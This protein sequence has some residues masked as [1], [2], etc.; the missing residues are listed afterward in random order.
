[1]KKN[2]MKRVIATAMVAVLLAT[3]P[4]NVALGAQVS[5]VKLEREVFKEVTEEETRKLHLSYKF[6]E[7]EFVVSDY[8]YQVL[9]DDA[10]A[11]NAEGM[12]DLPAKTISILI[13]QGKTVK[14]V[15]VNAKNKSVYENMLVAPS[16][17]F[18][19][20]TN[21]S[22]SVNEAATEGESAV[23]QNTVSQNDLKENQPE[24]NAN[25]TQ[26]EKKKEMLAEQETAK[27]AAS[28]KETL[29]N[30]KNQ[31]EEQEGEDVIKQIVPKELDFTNSEIY[32]RS[33]YI[34]DTLYPAKNY[35]KG[36]V[37]TVRGFQ[38]YTITLYPM[39]YSGTTLTYTDEMTVDITF[40][41][42]NTQSEY[43]PTQE[44]LAF[45]GS[46]IDTSQYA[47]TYF[48]KT[49]SK[50]S[51]GSSSK[52]GKTIAGSGKIDYII[53]TDK[54]LVKTFQE[55]ADYKASKGLRT[56]VVSTQKIYKKYKGYDRAEKI[57]NFIQDAYSKNKVTYILLGGDGD[58][59]TNSKQAV[60][61]TRLL[62][63]EPVSSGEKP[64]Y[65]A[66]DLYYSCLDGTY[67]RNN[68]HKYGE[69][70]DG[71]NGENVDL[72]ADV[73]VG[74]APVDNKEEAKNFITKT[75]NYETR[76]KSAQALMIGENL[77]GNMQCSAELAASLQSDIEAD[78]MTDT[79]RK[80]RDDKI[81]EEFINLY[82]DVNSFMKQLY[83]SDLEL[84]G[85]TISLLTEYT[86]ILKEYVETG[87]TQ[88]QLDAADIRCL[89]G[90]FEELAQAVKE[91]PSYTEQESKLYEEI[92]YFKDY[93][94]SCEGKSF[95][96]M[97]EGSRFYNAG[98]MATLDF[99][100]LAGNIFGGT[101]KD[102]IRL[103]SSSN[104]MVTRGFPEKYTVDTLYDRDWVNQHWETADLLAK[105]NASPELINHLGHS[106]V[107][108]V[109]RLDATQI[110]TLANENAFFF[111]S[112][113]CYA[114]SFDNCKTTGK[115]TK[116][117]SIA[118][119]LLVS[120]NKSGAFACI[121]NSRYGWY[122]SDPS[123]TKGPSQI[124]D[125]LFWDQ[126]LHE[127]DKSLG[128]ILAKS[129]E[130]KEAMSYLDNETYGTVMRYCYYEINL[131]G[132]PETSLHDLKDPLLTQPK[133][134]VKKA[135]NGRKLTWNA[136][137]K[138]SKY[139][140]Y[141][142]TSRNGE[143]EKIGTTKD[144]SYTDKT[145]QKGKTYYYKVAA[146]KKVGSKAYY[147]VSEMKKSK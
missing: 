61:P 38:V 6:G 94:G 123:S 121:V 91:N 33:V 53:I 40:K 2:R 104:N 147:R 59:K 55:L 140:V 32:N 12:P 72:K 118:E 113:G 28:E 14:S 145:A 76:Q 85:A 107:D 52:T 95:E 1:M 142:S 3:I 109:M 64:T 29:A 8:G 44:D 114:G 97:F 87:A 129:R 21:S 77:D 141:R 78:A 68:N 62:Y 84:L 93:L 96:Q 51:S 98:E 86:P 43:V 128:S 13:P 58:N 36:S 37:Q 92:I 119:E 127:K 50:D 65:I 17:G 143:Y 10:T 80:F 74:R 116:T 25:N 115:Y 4:S 90:Y 46:D 83:L 122:N 75:I 125:R 134:Q 146:Y 135:A 31:S 26:S 5:S 49:S 131:L 11:L 99:E 88:K 20:I 101:Y 66:S 19:K 16:I 22:V 63:C 139:V 110:R 132:D 105:L 7:P 103:G 45:L 48:Q 18:D 144:L 47:S 54:K 30:A 111:Y 57:R 108:R 138:A 106:D 112:Q 23:S 117:D 130:V 137:E 71:A 34:G 60:V 126:A 15:K 70:K 89:Q 133:L 56:A 67:D 100:S 81:K 120:S 24:S 41:K 69:E 27:E 79:I 42:S 35:S 136:V 9:L 39:S 102:E 73:Y 124:F 82:Y